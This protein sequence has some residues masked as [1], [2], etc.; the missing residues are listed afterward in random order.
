[1]K[2]RFILV[3][4]GK[5]AR[6]LHEERL[7]EVP[8]HFDIRE[9]RPPDWYSLHTEYSARR[10]CFANPV[11]EW[12]TE[13]R[14]ASWR[15]VP[16]LWASCRWSIEFCQFIETLVAGK[17]AP[18]II[19]IHPPYSDYCPNFCTFLSRFAIFEEWVARALPA[20]MVA[21]ENRIGSEYKRSPFLISYDSDVVQLLDEARNRS[22]SLKIVLDIPQLL[23]ALETK[24]S[25]DMAR[26][27]S[28]M[29]TLRQ[30]KESLVGVHMWGREP[31]PH[32]GSLVSM[33]NFDIDFMDECMQFLS[34]F[35]A[36]GVDRYLVPEVNDPSRAVFKGVIAD[37]RRYF[38]L[39]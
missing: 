10:R 27:S 35:F 34:E 8:G 2:A 5:H 22:S 1:M 29:D 39:I 18:S 4:Y 37:L 36:D 16:L 7:Q 23:M 3:K 6:G 15:G 9:I 26:V 32:Y 19:E 33:F 17:P 20:T 25:L 30:H 38:E 31:R 28:A 14:V 24:G 11:F 21:L 13:L 12:L